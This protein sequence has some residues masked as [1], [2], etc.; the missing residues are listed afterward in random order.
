MLCIHYTSREAYGCLT[1]A[2]IVDT[3]PDDNLIIVALKITSLEQ[4]R[5][6]V[7]CLQVGL[8]GAGILLDEAA[9]RDP[10]TACEGLTMWLNATFDAAADIADI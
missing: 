8:E 2:R 6:V 3:A 1:D 7:S 10:A 4:A 9:G 5:Q